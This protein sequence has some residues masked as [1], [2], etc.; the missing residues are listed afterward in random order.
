MTEELKTEQEGGEKKT[1]ASRG[2]KKKAD[3]GDD[4]ESLSGQAKAIATKIELQRLWFELFQTGK[5][6]Q[7]NGV[8]KSVY[9]TFTAKLKEIALEQ[10]N[11][12]PSAPT[13]TAPVFLP[14][15]QQFYQQAAPQQF[16]QAQE[17]ERK[18][19][20]LEQRRMWQQQQPQQPSETLL[21]AQQQA[22]LSA[23]YSISDSG[24]LLPP[25]PRPKPQPPP[26]KTVYA[27]DHNGVA[28]QQVS[29]STR[30][31]S[32]ESISTDTLVQMFGQSSNVNSN[33]QHPVEGVFVDSNIAY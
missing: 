24:Q 3:N 1:K 7:P 4:V 15:A 12:T 9:K 23:G 5:I 33:S 2:S 31:D 13:A 22:A 10:A 14:P 29:Y 21:S 32:G 11:P 30:A 6:P 26:N 28:P 16:S 17:I 18:R 19:N 8:S 27:G 25:P 20:L